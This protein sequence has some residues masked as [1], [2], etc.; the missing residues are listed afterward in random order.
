MATRRLAALT[1]LA[2][3]STATAQPQR[4][5]DLFGRILDTSEGGIAEAAVTVVNEDTGF[6]RLAQ[7]EPGGTYVVASLEAGVYKI[8]V[9]KEGFRSVIRFGVRVVSAGA[10]RADF[11]LPVGSIEESITVFGTVAMLGQ[12]DAATGDRFELSDVAHLPLNGRGVL[13]ILELVP[14]M[15]VIP[16]TRGEAGQFTTDGQ[17]PNTNYF[18]VDGVSANTGVSAGGLPAQSTGG[19]LPAMSAFGSLDA[20]IPVEAVEEFRLQTST[21]VAEFGR[22]PGASIGLHSRSGTNEF[23]GATTYRFRHELLSA[24]DWFGNQAGFGRQ[25][26]RLREWSQTLGGPAKRNRTFFFFSYEQMA[27]RQPYVWRQA[28]PSL[29]ARQGAASWAQP[30]LDLFPAPNQEVLPGGVAESVVQNVRPASLHAGSARVDQAITARISFFGRYSDSPSSNEFGSTAVNALDLRSQSLTLGLDARVA[31]GVVLDLRANESQSSAHSVWIEDSRPGAPGCVLAQVSGEIN[32]TDTPC[33]SLV[34]FSITG[35]GQVVSGREGDRR[36]R[37]FQIVHSAGIE[38]NRHSLKFGVDYR[39]ILAV[40]RDASRTSGLIAD[41]M[42]ALSDSRYFWRATSPALSQSTAVQELSLW[43]QDTWQATPRLTVAAGVR[44]EFSPAPLPA[45]QVNFLDPAS[46]APVAAIQP[47]WPSSYKNIA[48][49]LGVAYRL[50]EDGRTVLRAGG[51]LFYDSSMSIATDYINGGPLSL[52][53][54]QSSANAP[55]SSLDLEFGFMPNLQLPQVRQWNVTLERALEAH[56]VVSL[57]YVGTAGRSLI[58]REVGGAGNT[59][60][61]WL[62]LT[63]NHGASNYQALQAQYRRRVARGLQGVV[64]YTWSHSLD[65]DSSDAFLVWAGDGAGAARDHASSDFDLRHSLT[66]ALSYELPRA[67]GRMGVDAIFHARSGFPISVVDSEQYLGIALMNAF[68]PDLVWGE[69]LWIADRSAPGGRRINPAAF[70]VSGP[71]VQGTLGRNPLTGFGMSQ[72]D[73]AVRREF[74]LGERRTIQLRMEAFNALNQANFADPVNYLDRPAFGRSNSM[75][76]MMLGTG[77]PGS[78][79]A[80]VLQTGGPRT[81]QASLRFQF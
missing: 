43:A 61:R 12:R 33:D 44:W 18:T 54:F 8:T 52:A 27:L 26:L 74:R 5:A 2:W 6:R 40:R 65:D 76:N 55:F 49:R 36:Q 15:N 11:T 81:V 20:T 22:L 39:R 48:P 67:L 31:G 60:T 45:S 1:V 37:Q 42:R 75:L 29:D 68:R 4:Y 34:R 32:H 14:G 62:A 53:Q 13:T 73:L 17:R 72:V 51:G 77:S 70:A 59:A 69:P 24:N 38:R 63:T 9:R 19:A 58:R 57:G 56:G 7:S 41:G 46:D 78:G 28:V 10:T 47:L 64:S 35:I 3:V 21:T 25:A 50:T 30:I 66:A 16:A 80:P 79:L 71:S 23:H